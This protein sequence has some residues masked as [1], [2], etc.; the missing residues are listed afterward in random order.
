MPAS[1][2][3]P[4]DEKGSYFTLKILKEFKQ[5]DSVTIFHVKTDIMELTIPAEIDQ[6]KIDTLSS[7]FPPKIYFKNSNNVLVHYVLNTCGSK[8]SIQLKNLKEV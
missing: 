3:F 4:H 2:F 6:N 1:K 7:Q 8:R 5:G